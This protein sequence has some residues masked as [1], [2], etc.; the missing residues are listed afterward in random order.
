MCTN[1]SILCIQICFSGFYA[2]IIIIDIVSN[3][4]VGIGD[5]LLV[6]GLPSLSKLFESIF[7]PNSSK[8]ESYS[9][10]TKSCKMSTKKRKKNARVYY[11]QN[12]Y[13]SIINFVFILFDN[14]C[15]R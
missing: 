11:L 10:Q 13:R 9:Y 2:D 5:L 1:Q 14:F 6:V 7:N 8:F 3:D 12:K 15:R 4:N